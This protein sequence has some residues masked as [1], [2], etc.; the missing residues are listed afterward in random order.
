MS[1][2]ANPA[3]FTLSAEDQRGNIARLTLAQALAGANAVVVYATAAIIGHTLAPYKSL[4]TLPI[5]IFVVGMAVATLPAGV[6]AR[7]HGRRAAFLGGAY[8]AVVLSFRFAAAD[9]VAPERRAPALPCCGNGSR[10]CPW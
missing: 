3:A 8:G 1:N 10:G 5:S 9:C 4:A 6:L 7:R 2:S